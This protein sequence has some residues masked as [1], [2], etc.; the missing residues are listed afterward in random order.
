MKF[1]NYVAI[2]VLAL[3]AFQ[4][5]QAELIPFPEAQKKYTDN[6]IA[7]NAVKQAIIAHHTSENGKLSGYEQEMAAVCDQFYPAFEQAVTTYVTTTTQL[8]TPAVIFDIDETILSNVQLRIETDFKSETGS[9][10]SYVFRDKQRCTAIKP[11]VDLCKK[12]RALGCKVIFISARRGKEDHVLA[13]HANLIKEGITVDE[14]DGLFLKTM[15]V[16][17]GPG[18]LSNVVWKG[19]VREKLSERYEIIGCVGDHVDDI[20]G[21]FIGT[22]QVKLPNYL[23]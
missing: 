10:A 20:S 8:K 5:A 3:V 15:D 14:T 1:N 16:Y 9:D 11:S 21:Q 23:Y 19:S 6:P 12:L 2:G 13:T 22:V 17:T 18:K 7:L 4:Q